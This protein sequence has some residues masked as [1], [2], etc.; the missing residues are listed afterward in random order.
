MR[1]VVVVVS[2]LRFGTRPRSRFRLII[3]ALIAAV[4]DIITT[5]VIATVICAT[6]GA[7][8]CDI[9]WSELA[10]CHAN[11]ALGEIE[12]TCVVHEEDV[13]KVKVALFLQIEGHVNFLHREAA[14]VIV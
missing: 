11:P 10:Q 12:N 5:V 2:R 3:T 7:T 6:S 13:S 4:V 14:I 9:V 8:E 1:I